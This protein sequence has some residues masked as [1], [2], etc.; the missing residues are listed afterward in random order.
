MW[1]CAKTRGNEK[2]ALLYLKKQGLEAFRPE[3]HRYSIDPRT[4]IE[5]KRE[6]SLFPGYVFVRLARAADQSKAASAVGVAYLLGSWT[7]ERFLPREMPIGWMTSLHSAG[8]VIEGKKV[9]FRK[10]DKVRLALNAIA[11]VVAEVEGLDDAGNVRLKFDLLG[12]RHTI[13]VAA[14]RLE[15]AD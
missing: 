9:R 10:T 3:L 13:Q 15:R 6:L 4:R 14:D 7:G 1:I 2:R 8:P 12:K 5:R 11:D